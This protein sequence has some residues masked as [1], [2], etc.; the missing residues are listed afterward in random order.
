MIVW[1]PAVLS[2]FYAC[3]L[4]FCVCT[5]SAKLSKFHTGGTLLTVPW[6]RVEHTTALAL[7][8]V[9]PLPGS[10]I[11]SLSL[12]CRE[13]RGLL[14]AGTCGA[15]EHYTADL[16]VEV[17]WFCGFLVTVLTVRFS[18]LNVQTSCW[19]EYAALE[20]FWTAA[21]RM[22][23]FL[24]TASVRWAELYCSL[25]MDCPSSSLL[26]CVAKQIHW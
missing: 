16:Y 15:E 10:A 19:E 18:V 24:F 8:V 20:I 26:T 2:D 1:T 11:S 14:A 9:R 23:I 25:Y 17:D 22:L 12:V 21:S 7:V 13:E 4:C 5:C 3:V 6:R